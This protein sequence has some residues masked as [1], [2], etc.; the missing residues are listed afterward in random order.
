MWFNR[1]APYK[2]NVS[3]PTAKGEHKEK[4]GKCHSHDRSRVP[5]FVHFAC[6]SMLR[7]QQQQQMVWQYSQ[8]FFVSGMAMAATVVGRALVGDLTKNKLMFTTM[9]LSVGAVAFLTDMLYIKASA[10]R[11]DK[12][13][14]NLGFFLLRLV[15]SIPAAVIGGSAIALSSSPSG[16][17]FAAGFAAVAATMYLSMGSLRL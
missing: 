9:A 15:L 1:A 10:T 3:A 7:I 8:A 4:N 6:G 13:G 5:L 17:M 16:A 14:M 2:E 12:G 11:S